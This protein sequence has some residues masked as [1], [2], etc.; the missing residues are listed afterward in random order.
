MQRNRNDDLGTDFSEAAC[1]MLGPKSP[2]AF[3]KGF[4]PPI[5]HGEDDFPKKPL[6]WPEANSAIEMKA[7]VAAAGTAFREVGECADRTAATGTGG[8]RVMGERL[9]ASRTKIH[10]GIGQ[11]GFTP[12]ANV[13][14]DEI[15][16]ATS[17][18]E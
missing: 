18:I 13:R 16:K 4:V 11:E 6:V 17:E 15:A 7:I 14:V 9:H 3:A 12:N 5:L 8:K 10:C 2:N 1:V